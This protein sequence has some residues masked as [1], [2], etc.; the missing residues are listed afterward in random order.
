M[1]I[2]VIN[3]AKDTERRESIKKQAETFG[4]QI[5]FID[6]VNGKDLSDNDI[7]QLC[8]DFHGNGMTL[9]VL[10]CSLSHLK[11][12]EKIINDN[13]DMALILEDDAKLNKAVSSVYSLIEK[14]N[15]RSKNKSFIYL[16]SITNEYIDTFKNR[17]ST[18]YSLVNVIDADY[19]YGYIINN[20]ADKNLVKFL[21][22]I[23]I[24]ADKWRFM[25]ERGVVKIKAVIPPAISITDLSNKSTLVGD[26]SITLQK[27]IYFFDEQYR[28][29]SLK[30]KT[31]S[32]L[33]RVFI[34]SWV[35]R[36]KP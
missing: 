35:K 2:F 9:G 29:R 23:W 3:L 16:L 17:L 1:N 8:K 12:Y 31:K 26:R 27:R 21:K 14:Y 32:F 30:I 11:I 34:R 13:L 24:E 18:K 15:L 20:T 6:A 33:W 36:V 22:P 5:Q 4:L 28:N 25:Q 7:N 10:G 19:G